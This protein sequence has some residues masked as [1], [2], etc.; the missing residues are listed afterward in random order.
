MRRYSNT[1]LPI[2]QVSLHNENAIMHLNY[3]IRKEG[4]SF[5]DSIALIHFSD[6][7]NEQK[8]SESLHIKREIV[9]CKKEKK[10]TMIFTI[11]FHEHNLHRLRFCAILSSSGTLVVRRNLFCIIGQ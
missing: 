10:S 2:N 7:Y 9:I 5:I 11:T 1:I 6:R 8:L 4:L 3:I